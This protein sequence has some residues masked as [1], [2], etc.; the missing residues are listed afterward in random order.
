MAS[1]FIHRP[2]VAIVIAILMTMIG[3][4]SMVGLP[5][6]LHGSSLEEL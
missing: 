6:M 2:I 4:V 1:F 5:S 3:L